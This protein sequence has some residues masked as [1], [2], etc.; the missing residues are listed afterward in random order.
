MIT[1]VNA[2]KSSLVHTVPSPQAAIIT[3]IPA[4]VQNLAQTVNTVKSPMLHTVQSPHAATTPTPTPI[5]VSVQNLAQT[6][7][8]VKSPMLHTVQSPQAAMATTQIP[9]SVQNLAQT[10]NPVKSP[11]LHTV[12]SPQAAMATTQIPVSVQNLAQT[13]NPVKSPM[14]HTVQSPQAAMATTQIPVSVQ[15]LAQ[16]VNPVKSPMLHTVQSPQAAMAT[17][18]IPVSVQN[19]AQTVNP[20]KSPMLHTVQ[21]S[22]AAMATTHIPVSVK[23]LTQT[24]LQAISQVVTGST[25]CIPTLASISNSIQGKPQSPMFSQASIQSILRAT[26]QNIAPVQSIATMGNSMTTGTITVPATVMTATITLPRQ[27]HI[28][29]HTAMT[30]QP[31]QI[32]QPIVTIAGH[33]HR[34]AIFTTNQ[35]ATLITQPQAI[36]Q[37][38]STG[39]PT[40]ILAQVGVPRQQRQIPP[41]ITVAHP[42]LQSGHILQ[43]A[44]VQAAANTPNQV[45]QASLAQSQLMKTAVG[46]AQQITLQKAI[47]PRLLQASTVQ[48]M[49]QTSASQKT[50]MPS[51]VLPQTIVKSPQQLGPPTLLPATS[52]SMASP[53]IQTTIVHQPSGV[54][55]QII[56]Q[57]GAAAAAAVAAHAAQQGMQASRQLQQ[58]IVSTVTPTSHLLTKPV[59]T[60][61]GAHPLVHQAVLRAGTPLNSTHMVTLGQQVHLQPIAQTTFVK[62][63]SLPK[64]T[65]IQPATIQLQA[66]QHPQLAQI[67]LPNQQVQVQQTSPQPQ[68]HLQQSTQLPFQQFQ[69]V[70][71]QQTQMVAQQ[72]PQQPVKSHDTAIKPESV[73]ETVDEPEEEFLLLEEEEEREPISAIDL[74]IMK[75]LLYPQA[76]MEKK[77]K[78]ESENKPQNEETEH[79]DALT[80]ESPEFTWE[81]YLEVTGAMSSPHSAFKHVEHSLESPFVAGMKLEVV[82]R[83][84]QAGQTKTF[85]VATVIATCGQLLL[86]RYDGYEEARHSDFWC[87]ITSG[88]LHPIGW[89]AQNSQQLSPPEE[90]KYRCDNWSD[91]LIQDLTGAI[92]A[93]VFL[94][95]GDAGKVLA[96]QIK[97]GMR[98]EVTD[99]LNPLEVWIATV[100]ENHSGRLLLRWEGSQAN[101]DAHDFWLFYQSH[102][103]HPMGWAA[104]NQ[105]KGIVLKPP[106]V[107]VAGLP[108]STPEWSYIH[109]KAGLAASTK[110]LP[111]GFFKHQETVREHYF[112][113]GMKLEAINPKAPSQI[114][115][116]TIT[117]I[118]NSNYFLVEI[119]D[120][121]ADKTPIQFV[122]YGECGGLFYVEW[123]K[124]HNVQIKIPNGYDCTSFDWNAYLK[125]C[126]SQ[127][128]SK[129]LFRTVSPDHEFQRGMKLEAVN[130]FNL[131][132]ICV[133]TVTKIID[134]HMW[135]NFDGW[136]LPNHIVDV[137]SHDIFPVGWC[138][139]AGLLLKQPKKL[140]IKKTKKVAVVWPEKQVS[141]KST[142]L[143][144]GRDLYQKMKEGPP[145]TD[146]SGEEG[147]ASHW[148]PKIYFNHKCF[149][150]PYLNKG[151]I[152]ELPRAVGPGIVTLVLKEVIS[153]LINA[154]YKPPRVLRELQVQHEETA[155]MN[156]HLQVMKAKYKS[157][158][159]RAMVEICKNA[160][161]V[162]SFCRDMCIKLECCPNLVALD[163]IEDNCPENCSTLTKTK[164]THYYGK[165]KRSR[166]GRPP[167]GHSNLEY[168]PK[169]PGKR[170]KKRKPFVH[171][172]KRTSSN[173]EAGGGLENGEEEEVSENEEE[174]EEALAIKRRKKE[175]RRKEK[176][177]R[178]GLKRPL[179]M[180]RAK[181]LLESAKRAKLPHKMVLPDRERGKKMKTR[182]GHIHKSHHHHH[183]HHHAGSSNVTHKIKSETRDRNNE[184]FL[185]LDSNPLHW[186]VQVVVDFIKSTDCAPLAKI[187]KEQEID[188]Q[189]LLLLT[190]PTVQECMELKLGPAIKLCHHI[191]RVKIAFYEQYAK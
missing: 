151:R 25:T 99:V 183:H 154:A 33:Q 152:A 186:S 53:V 123:C 138:E 149:S 171:R 134:R 24:S 73:P 5:P 157:K 169:K 47:P 61:A 63:P 21:S 141:G 110:P 133:A 146:E 94:L 126:N 75:N 95:E 175:E 124:Q 6:V 111:K 55:T 9:V 12:Q 31:H 109:Q 54:Q 106:A 76:P 164:Y 179:I 107:L 57:P 118:F 70:P 42:A 19:L 86:L 127:A 58:Q 96:E 185:Q 102:R 125:H 140:M 147:K 97:A 27:L 74:A 83:N 139:S 84:I 4:S 43:K 82:N 77:K 184:D 159:Y 23:N 39:A 176:E 3:Q 66:T 69:Q 156:G 91:F 44:V 41:N 150:G 20:V 14:L 37:A 129:N 190:L 153:L 11:M 10:V 85:W 135:L 89:C 78:I 36:V 145:R 155:G 60:Q 182:F 189:A 165:K 148:S 52:T 162:E 68:L 88:D 143:S 136:K 137:E 62:Q 166:V 7:N 56:Q 191:E 46:G 105:D 2:V 34:H 32:G 108:Y 22:Q 64:L 29:P 8:P 122:G 158:S 59:F 120:L 13:V 100:K 188:G 170:R 92:T 87:D 167:G 161:E 30:L 45:V 114:C 48:Q 187:F 131:N 1:E 132:Q 50:I 121:S 119:D 128:A 172:K 174:D 28:Q 15:N 38:G 103:I 17:T 163:Q 18:Q 113:V 142:P 35:R 160:D 72:Q 117:K 98:V 79:A 180:T 181:A 101:T 49:I 40:Q 178:M 115:P 26:S 93:P 80:E 65:Q 90:I 168:G 104:K 130:P 67:Q 16:T 81:E 173:E 144:P 51:T 177:K 112:R 71:L 116:A